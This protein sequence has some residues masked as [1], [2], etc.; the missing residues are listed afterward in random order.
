MDPED[1]RTLIDDGSMSRPAVIQQQRSEIERITGIEPPHDFAEMS[2][3]WSKNK[4]YVSRKVN[5]QLPDDENDD[6]EIENEN[7]NE[8]ETVDDGE[9]DD[10]NEEP[11]EDFDINE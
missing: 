4:S 6:D 11:I 9:F 5:E 10:E 2:E 1:L 3:W 8:N 7:E